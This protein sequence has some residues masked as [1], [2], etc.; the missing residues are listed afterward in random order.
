M[1]AGSCYDSLRVTESVKPDTPDFT[2]KDRQ[3]VDIYDNNNLSYNG[4]QVTFDLQSLVNSHRFLDLKSSY[5]TIPLTVNVD[6][7][8]VGNTMHSDA[9]NAFAVSLK[10]GTHQ[11]INGLTVNLA[12]QSVLNLQQFTNI[13]ATYQ[14]LSTWNDTDQEVFGPSVNFHKDNG[15]SMTWSSTLGEVNNSIALATAPTLANPN[16]INNGRLKRVTKNWALPVNN[17]TYVSNTTPNVL[18]NSM[19]G[20]ALARTN[21]TEVQRSIVDV[22]ATVTTRLSF[23]ILA[24]VYL[25]HIADLFDK[26]PIHRGALWQMTFHT[27]LP[28][29]YSQ[30]LAATSLQPNAAPSVLQAANGF[31]PFMISQPAPS[32]GLLTGLSIAGTAT[33]TLSFTSNI[34]NSM[35]STCVLHCAMMDLENSVSAAYIANPRRRVVYRDF[36]RH[37]PGP[38]QNVV[39]LAAARAN[40]SAGI[41]KPRGLLIFPHLAT[42]GAGAP[43]NGSYNVPSLMSPWSSCGGTTAYGAVLNSFNVQVNGANIYEKNIRYRYDHFLREQ[44]GVLSPSGNGVDGMR[45][46]L[47]DEMDFNS[48]HGWI[49]VNLE[50]HPKANDNVPAS[51]DIEITNGSQMVMNYMTF[52]FYEREFEIDSFT[53]KLV[54]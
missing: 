10:N 6:I 9:V 22:G 12:N 32:S 33:G 4:G 46:G 5:L 38:L 45:V 34:G 3:F 37:A 1:S 52:V 42:Q 44:F 36:V 47:L 29:N 8:G 18:G 20:Q 43:G 7:S 31:C 15:Q 50:R 35:Q 2:C 27:H 54:I 14:L 19:L 21:L 41:A 28:Y 11:L 53:G 49:Y 13:P 48:A 30:V 40:I 23:Q 17:A 25:K 39:P 16:P 51:I 26:M 24:Q